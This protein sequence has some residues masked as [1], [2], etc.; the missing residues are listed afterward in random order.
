MRPE[1]SEIVERSR[2][3]ELRISPSLCI[4]FGYNINSFSPSDTAREAVGYW[5]EADYDVEVDDSLA[6][7]AGLGLDWFVS[8]RVALNGEAAWILNKGDATETFDGVAVSSGDFNGSSIS[9]RLG[10]RVFF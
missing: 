8:D 10:V 5:Y 2:L 4:G 3:L 6:V 7:K 1:M 9:L